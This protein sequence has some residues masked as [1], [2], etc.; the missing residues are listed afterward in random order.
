MGVVLGMHGVLDM[1]VV[2]GVIVVLGVRVVLGV[3]V[4]E[5]AQHDAGEEDTEED[6]DVPRARV[7]A[8]GDAGAGG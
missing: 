7:V 2:L 3:C 8:D 6:V 5:G 4:A 1:H